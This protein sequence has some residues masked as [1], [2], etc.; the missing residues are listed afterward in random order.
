MSVGTA[1]SDGL[2]ESPSADRFVFGPD[3]RFAVRARGTRRNTR[4]FP[5]NTLCF[6]R[7]SEGWCSGTLI[8]PQVVLTAGH[9]M[10]GLPLTVVPGADMQ[11]AQVRDQMPF[12]SQVV[13]VANFRRHPTDDFGIL[14]LPRA[15]PHSRFMRL[16]TRSAANSRTLLTLAGYP[17]D[18]PEGTLWAHS[19]RILRVTPTR[20]EYR[21]DTAG[22]QSGSPVWLLGNA[23]IRLILAVHLGF[24]RDID[25]TPIHN[26]GL[27]IT[28]EVVDAIFAW[29]RAAGVTLPT[30]DAYQTHC[31]GGRRLADSSP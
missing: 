18:Q 31:T 3:E 13:P 7:D 5:F 14:L 10:I 23:G 30:R 19:E 25:G 6:L 8:A 12:G 29:C 27:R 11:A 22:N 9:C 4:E 2:L 21:I 26:H 20:L 16:Q 24:V 15:F 17:I 1:F 28:C